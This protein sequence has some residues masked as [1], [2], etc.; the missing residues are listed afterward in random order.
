ML[1]KQHYGYLCMACG[2]NFEVIYG[3]LGHE[4][5]EC[6]HLNPLSERPGNEGK[7]TLTK[8]EEVAVL[9]A[10]CHRMV[11][12]RR[13]ALSLEELSQNQSIEASS[14][15]TKEGIRWP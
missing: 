6:H 11:H 5:I 9:C 15:M 10:N 7:R 1:A 12:R 2:F 4:Y 3:R 13:P 14:L 8:I